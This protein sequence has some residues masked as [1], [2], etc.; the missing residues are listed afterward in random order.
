[1]ELP[2][3]KGVTGGGVYAA[4]RLPL[5]LDL[6]WYGCR[7]VVLVVGCVA[8]A[9]G[10]M[11]VVVK[12]EVGESEDEEVYNVRLEVVVVVVVGEVCLS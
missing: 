11:D 5:D 1:M 7:V 3:A 8:D 6:R 10:P 4:K 9:V 2:G 12:L